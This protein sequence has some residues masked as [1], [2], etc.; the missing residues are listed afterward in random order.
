MVQVGSA[1]LPSGEQRHLR[2]TR[3][4]ADGL[5]DSDVG[6]RLNVYVAVGSLIRHIA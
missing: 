6:G 5:T 3:C 4:R 1:R 2:Q